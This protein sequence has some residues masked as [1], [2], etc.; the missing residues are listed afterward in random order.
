MEERRR[1]VAIE[2][3][4]KTLVAIDDL[5]GQLGLRTRGE[6]VERILEEV[7]FGPT[8]EQK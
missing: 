2:L 1:R 6:L 3:S 4:E 8:E 7:L 5:K